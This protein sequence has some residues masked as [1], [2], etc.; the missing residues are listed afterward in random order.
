M[1]FSFEKVR[2][3]H[4][5]CVVD[6]VNINL[7]VHGRRADL[8]ASSC[9]WGFAVGGIDRGEDLN[10]SSSSCGFGSSL[11]TARFFAP[12]LFPV[13]LSLNWTWHRGR[14]L[15]LDCSELFIRLPLSSL[16]DSVRNL[17]IDL[18]SMLNW[19]IYLHFICSSRCAHWAASSRSLGSP[20]LIFIS[21]SGSFNAAK[22]ASW[23]TWLAMVDFSPGYDNN[24]S[25]WISWTESR[26]GSFVSSTSYSSLWNFSWMPVPPKRD[27]SFRASCSLV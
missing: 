6:R 10:C 16:S 22:N 3:D 15:V 12:W 1:C 21:N 8:A 13:L 9:L 7:Y 24:S 4:T 27:A 14:Q 26:I 17:P 11:V 18:V 23:A 20:S 19:R 2:R 5:T 25:L